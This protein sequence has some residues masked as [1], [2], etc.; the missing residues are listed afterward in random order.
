LQN[1]LEEVHDDLA[2]VVKPVVE[3]EKVALVV[4]LDAVIIEEDQDAIAQVV[5]LN[6]VTLGVEQEVTEEEEQFVI[7]NDFG[8]EKAS[9]LE[10]KIRKEDEIDANEDGKKANSVKREDNIVESNSLGMCSSMLQLIKGT[11]NHMQKLKMNGRL[12]R[13]KET[14]SVEEKKKKYNEIYSDKHEESKDT[15]RQY[16]QET[17]R[18]KVMGMFGY[19]IQVISSQIKLT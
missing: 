17:Q 10:F 9:G 13:N 16:S 1:D 19:A 4:N 5:N 15:G 3:Q 11:F 2:S 8:T 18:K 6:K 12:E 7:D 14:I